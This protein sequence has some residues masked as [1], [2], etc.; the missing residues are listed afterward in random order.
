NRNSWNQRTVAH[1]DS[2]FYDVPG[3]L[4]G[5]SS[6]KEIESGLLGDLKGK[7]ILH[8]QCHFGQDSISLARKGA[9]VTGVDLS[10]VA[11]DNARNLAVKTNT[12]S[13]AEFICC[14]V[15]ELP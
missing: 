13:A 8:L 15:Y 6:L 11:I 12:E 14:D 1:L 7:T 4:K 5:A 3:F 9:Q 10:N 2:E